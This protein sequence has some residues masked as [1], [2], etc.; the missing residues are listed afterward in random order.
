MISTSAADI[1]W[2]IL[3]IT[4]T[5]R[6]GLCYYEYGQG[7]GPSASTILQQPAFLPMTDNDFRQDFPRDFLLLDTNSR[8]NNVLSHVYCCYFH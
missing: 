1:E 7:K 3:G 8:A 2:T 4:Q 5:G 6:Y